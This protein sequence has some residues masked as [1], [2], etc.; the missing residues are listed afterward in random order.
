MKKSFDQTFRLTTSLV[1]SVVTPKSCIVQSALSPVRS[2][3]C[4]L[5]A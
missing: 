5:L 2:V 3:E 4:G 1:L